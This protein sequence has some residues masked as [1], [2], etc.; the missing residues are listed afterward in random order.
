MGKPPRKLG[1]P[2]L[3]PDRARFRRQYRCSEWARKRAALIEKRSACEVCGRKAENGVV[4]QIHHKRYRSDRRV[5]DYPDE[6]L[7]VL[8]KGCHARQHGLI[9]PDSGWILEEELDLGNLS[10]QCEKC[11]TSNRYQFVLVH[12]EWS[13]VWSVGAVCC[14]H[15]TSDARAKDFAERAQKLQR[16][17]GAFVNPLALHWSGPKNDDGSNGP[18]DSC[19]M[20]GKLWHVNRRGFWEGK[21]WRVV[22]D[23]LFQELDA[24][25]NPMRRE[26]E[27]LASDVES[28]LEC[29]HIIFDL[30]QD[31]R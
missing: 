14:Q 1:T 12:P 2:K 22:Y 21:G 18:I 11:G 26:A 9:P 4:L 6:E 15:L 28:A 16:S 7:Q 17:R 24:T 10:G 29:R 20:E 5:W 13:N 3:V 19:R 25:G 27:V 23:V 30:Y 8:C 31:I